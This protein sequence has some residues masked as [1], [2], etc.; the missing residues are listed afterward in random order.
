MCEPDHYRAEC[1]GYNPSIDQ[2]SLCLSNGYRLKGELNEKSDFLCFC[3]NCHYGKMCEFSNELM[4]FTLDSLTVKDLQ[5]S[6]KLSTVFYI[7]ITVLIFLFGLFNNLSNFLTFARPKSRIFSVGNYLLIVSVVNQ[8]SLLFLL[9]KII[10]IILGSN[11][12]LFYYESLNLYS[13]KI[14]SYLLSVFTRRTNWLASLVTLERLCMVLFPTSATFKNTRRAFGLSIF[15]IL[16]VSGMHVHEAM[17]YTTIVDPSYA[18]VTI[19]LCVTSYIQQLISV[20]NRV[21]VLIHY[22]APFAIQ[23]VSVTIL[24]VQT[25]RSRARANTSNKDTF[26]DLF[27]KQFKTHREHYITPMIIVLSS[28]PQ[29][30]LSFS[31]ACTE[32]K[33]PWQRYMLLTTYFL[34]YLPQM[35]GFILYVLPSTAFTEEF[36][37][38]IIGKRFIRKQR[39]PIIAKKQNIEMKTK[40]PKSPVPNVVS[41]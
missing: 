18:S 19:T 6:P 9:L 38:T 13:C 41:S 23:V 17:H 25:A 33:Q 15:V 16:T 1:F 4:S 32:L 31:Y 22:F 35:L 2:C 10:H 3:S 14:I 28:L 20:Y 39:G 30:A 5:T 40:P 34:S 24:I 21:N 11:G 37:Q 26:I 36:H 29:I 12:T 27:K 7:S 8:C